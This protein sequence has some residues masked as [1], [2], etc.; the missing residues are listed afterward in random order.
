[1]GV[2][3]VPDRAT[4]APQSSSKPVARRLYPARP[5][6][7][8]AGPVRHGAVRIGE[9]RRGPARVLEAAT[10]TPA[11]TAGPGG[12]HGHGIVSVGSMGGGVGGRDTWINGDLCLAGNVALLV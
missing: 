8:S 9:A 11:A 12:V 2:R 1:V 5:R 7:A 10:P 4:A 3:R 6:G